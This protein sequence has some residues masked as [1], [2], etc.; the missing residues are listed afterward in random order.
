MYPENSACGYMPLVRYALGIHFSARFPPDFPTEYVLCTCNR[1]HSRERERE[2]D[3]QGK[4]QSM[5]RGS[6][7]SERGNGG[8]GIEGD[9]EL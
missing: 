4:K 5:Q 3:M 1:N 2:R 7:T 6:S 9:V 8:A